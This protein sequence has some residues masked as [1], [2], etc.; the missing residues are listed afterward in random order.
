MPDWMAYVRRHLDVSR[1]TSAREGEIL[2]DL[3]RQFEDVYREGLARGLSEAA[4]EE[5]ARQQ[6]T[7]WRAFAEDIYRT[8]RQSL[9]PRVEKWADRAGQVSE[10]GTTGRPLRR[11]ASGLTLDVLQ[12]ARLLAR[13][14]M[15]T[16]VVVLTLALGIGANTA[17]FT[18]LDQVLLRALP[19][20]RPDELVILRYTGPNTGR[21][22]GDGLHAF[23]Y[24]M[25]RDLAAAGSSVAELAG[26]YQTA[27]NLTAGPRAERV[28]AELVTGN[29][30]GVLRL[31]PASGRLIMPAD[32][33]VAGAHPVVVLS[34]DFWQRRFGADP[35]TV[36][37]TVRVNGHPMT[38]IGV[39]PRGF[40]GTD[41]GTAPDL[42]LPVAMKAAAT[43]TW[44]E[45]ERRR[46]QW[47][48]V[49]GRLRPGTA[50]GQAE[51]VLRVA[52]RQARVMEVK[53][54]TRFSESLRT[55]FVESP[56]FVDPG[57]HGLSQLREQF[58][59]PLALLMGMVGLVLLITCANIANLLLARAPARQR[60]MAVRAA[61]GA[62][63]GRMVRRLLVESAL[64]A[65][66]SGVLGGAFAVWSG[67]ALLRMLP[68][69]GGEA[70][71]TTPDARVLG[72]VA[73][74]SLAT[75]LVFGLVPAIQA[76]RP[77][78][79]DS[80]KEGERTVAMGHGRLRKGLVVAQVAL[81]VLLLVAAGLFARTL[82]NLRSL[83]PGFESRGVW[84]ASVDPTLSGHDTPHTL[85]YYRRLR[86][87]LD[88]TPGVTATAFASVAPMTDQM[89]ISTIKVE[90][91]QPKDGEDMNPHVNN[92]S[93]GY[94]RT[95]GQKLIAGRDFT[96][97]DRADSAEVAIISR[98]LAQAYFGN[99]NP[100][101]RRIGFRQ[102]QP[103]AVEI[104]GVVEDSHD[105]VLRDGIGRVVYTPYLQ[106]S[107]LSQLTVFTRLAPG[108]APDVIRQVA[109]Q[110][111]PS[112]PVFDVKSMEAQK[113]E[114]LYIERMVATLSVMFGGLATLLSAVGIYGVM[115][116]T[117]ARR[118]REIGLRMALGAPQ[119]RVLWLVMREVVALGA[120]GTILGV[121]A[122]LA[123]GRF[124]QSQ[125]FG[126]SGSDPLT[127]VCAAAG[128]LTVSLTAGYLPAARAA[129]V[130][131]LTALRQ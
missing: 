49:F 12:A 36:G 89:M 108:V 4:A 131:P 122:A 120:V 73:L 44:D 38:V 100:V 94:F 43:P 2:E 105:T 45:L 111:D 103:P 31:S 48:Q 96:D 92:V 124:A 42:Y 99:T 40:S 107:E 61:L 81:S 93:P 63:T 52:F 10:A 109:I 15:F 17:I 53:E 77:G 55:Q 1:L 29:Y 88:R 82:W 8:N 25:Y 35:A 28:A 123:A 71:S 117:V 84:T 75:A 66:A 98:S 128:L 97:H 118:T 3:A 72:F 13:Q 26:H 126:L 6:V 79:A 130:D 27:V 121:P 20:D 76:A 50:R 101:G 85:E 83:D 33:R 65:A 22:Q 51:A 68:G 64:L 30:F 39:A 19:V 14:P 56:L 69:T 59:E 78:L 41:V 113:T 32:D 21:L 74:V 104:V 24:P 46:S 87:A 119:G 58:A 23:S 16:A 102:S 91:Y 86:D 114:S 57:S 70:L 5:A 112:V 11:L 7:D 9:R 18:L 129:R 54:L 60:E 67:D 47:L 115:S 127:L 62:T 95:I 34:H 90:G 116:Y 125:L 106:D 37:Q 110:V 80:L